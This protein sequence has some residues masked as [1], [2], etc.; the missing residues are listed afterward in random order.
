VVKRIDL[1][2]SQSEATREPF[3][4]PRLAAPARPDDRHPH[5]RSLQ[6]ARARASRRGVCY[7]SGPVPR[8][9]LALW[10]LSMLAL[11]VQHLKWIVWEH[12]DCRKHGVKNSECRCKA[13]LILYL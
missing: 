3:R 6:P 9:L 1:D 8:P 4:D 13:R 10:I 2:V 11:E 12:W 7:K 5:V